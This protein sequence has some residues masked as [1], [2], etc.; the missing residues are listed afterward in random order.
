[1][2]FEVSVSRRLGT[3]TIAF[4]FASDAPVTALVGPSGAGKTSLLNM[5]A[6]IL[7]PECGRIV[8]GGRVLFDSTAVIDLPPEARACGYVFQDDRLFPHLNVRAN[9]L[10]GQRLARPEARLADYDEVVELLG[11]AHLADRRPRT[12]SGGEARRVAIGRALLAGPAM[13]LLDEP[14]TSLDA[15]RRQ[16]MLRTLERIRDQFGRPILYVSHQEDEVRRIAG[17]VVRMDLPERRD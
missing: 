9:L 2:S 10:Y 8:V 16:E 4:D 14:L 11:I 17:A 13:L 7:R 15:D 3:A 1:M 5:I 6:G 12:L